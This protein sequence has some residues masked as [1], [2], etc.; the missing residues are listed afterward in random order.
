M[1]SSGSHNPKSAT[2]RILSL[3]GGGAKGFYTLGILKEIEA[4]VHCPLCEKFPLM[5]GTSTGAIIASL[6]A[7]GR[8]V[9]ETH[10]LYREHVPTIMRPTSRSEKSSVLTR[11]AKS[12]FEDLDFSAFKTDVGIV[13]T[14]WNLERPM[15]FKTDIRQAHGRP[16]TFIPGFGCKI[17]DAVRAS[18]SAFPFFDRCRLSIGEGQVVELADGGYCANNPTLYALADA[19]RSLKEHPSNL[20]L[21]SLGVGTYPEPKYRLVKRWV[22]KWPSVRLLQKT[23]NIN[24]TSMDQLRHV[25]FG[26]IPTIRISDTFSTPEM[27]TDLMEHNLAK[28]DILYQRGRESFA[29]HEVALREFLI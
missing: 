27:A 15:I 20:R 18:C 3:D 2:F 1:S 11:V 5:F 29:Q 26:E 25:L 17:A 13:A 6:L 22:R 28:L 21:I 16:A 10:A 4:L 7:L 19:V 12:V 9:D 8:S 24:T 14:Q 23:L